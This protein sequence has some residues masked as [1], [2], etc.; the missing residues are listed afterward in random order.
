M[1]ARLFAASIGLSLLVTQPTTA[2]EITAFVTGAARRAYE[3]LAPQFERATGHKLVSQF[4]L[5]PNLVKKIDAGEPFDVIILSYDVESLIKQGKVV[6]NSRT[7][8]GRIGVGV[9]VRQGA[10]KPDFSTVEAFKRSLLDAK[11]IAT[12]GEGSSGRYVASLIER[13]GIAEQVKPKIR[14]GPGGTSAQLVSRGEVDFVVSGLPPLIG[15]PNIE[16][17]GYL[18]EEI[19]SWLVFSGGVGV[20]AKEPDAARALL[21]FLTT[22]AAIAVFKANGLEP[23]Q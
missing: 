5:P 6:A 22:P 3:T 8:F 7:V 10:P 1:K 16:W 18:P 9:A 19:N 13:L 23:P 11:T 17:L 20:N 12:S 15:T 4:D 21:G 14:S 2:A